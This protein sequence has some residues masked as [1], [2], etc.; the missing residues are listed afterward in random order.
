MGKYSNI[1]GAP[2]T[3]IH[4]IRIFD[5]AVVDLLLTMILA[6]FVRLDDKY[7]YSLAIWLVIGLVVHKLFDVRNSS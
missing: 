5:I 3:G 4:S 1:F 2:G 7:I 6:Y